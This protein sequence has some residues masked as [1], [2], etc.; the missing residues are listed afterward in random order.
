MEFPMR[1]IALMCALLWMAP[2][3]AEEVYKTMDAAGN[4]IY[5]DKPSPEAETIQIQEAQTVPADDAPP[6]TYTA[7]AQAESSYTRAR[8]VSPANDEALRPEDETVQVSA[9]VEPSYQGR[10]IVVLFLD[11]KEHSRGK[12]LS[13][14]LTGLERG[15][16]QVQV[17]VI[18]AAGK[19][20]VSS[21]SASFHV[22]KNAIPPKKAPAPKPPKPPKAP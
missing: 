7:P 14:T 4:V 11:G 19:E 3:A 13:W 22:L 1:L 6:F 15:T 10:D 20:L 8:I 18:S 16:H 9:T 5:S 17:K 21:G 12:S 2:V